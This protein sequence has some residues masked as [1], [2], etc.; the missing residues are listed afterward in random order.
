[1]LQSPWVIGGGWIGP[2]AGAIVAGRV[3][4]ENR[5]L[6]VMREEAEAIGTVAGARAEPVILDLIAAEV[7]DRGI[8]VAAVEDHHHVI[9]QI[10]HVEQNGIIWIARPIRIQ[11]LHP[12]VNVIRGVDDGDSGVGGD[13]IGCIHPD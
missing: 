2:G 10:I 12:H 11:P 3:E 1:M 9:D 6:R 13:V 8:E 5:V 4:P 7:G